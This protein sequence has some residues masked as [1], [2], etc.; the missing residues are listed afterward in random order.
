MGCEVVPAGAMSLRRT[1]VNENSREER[2]VGDTPTA[3]YM[4]ISELI[5]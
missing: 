2:V 1:L 5:R 3:H 4:N